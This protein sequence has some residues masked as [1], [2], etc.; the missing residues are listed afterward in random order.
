MEHEKPKILV[1]DSGFD[2]KSALI[3]ATIKEK[4][5]ND[6]IIV[7]PEE[8]RGKGLTDFANSPPMKITTPSLVKMVSYGDTQTG[9]EKRRDRRKKERNKKH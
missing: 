2:G 4:Y 3:I 6:V 9:Q 5:G 7:T 1:I 8:A